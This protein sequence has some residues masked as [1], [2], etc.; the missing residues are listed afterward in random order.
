MLT[1]ERRIYFTIYEHAINIRSYYRKESAASPP[2]DQR[3]GSMRN[4][5]NDKA[6]SYKL[7]LGQDMRRD[8]LDILK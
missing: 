4:L 8:D 7:P 3:E 1:V 5:L 2:R 6:G